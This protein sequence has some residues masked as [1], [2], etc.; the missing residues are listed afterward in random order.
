MA[1]ATG[2]VY[3]CTPVAAHRMVAVTGAVA[4]VRSPAAQACCSAQVGDCL[5][6]R[7]RDPVAVH[8]GSTATAA[9]N[10][11]ANLSCEV[12]REREREERETLRRAE[13]TR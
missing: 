4:A 11:R 10:E 5:D 12:E 8:P 7:D 1:T 3:W 6:W 9:E 13:R 2:D